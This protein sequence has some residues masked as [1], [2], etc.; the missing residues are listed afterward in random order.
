MAG[1][2]HSRKLDR[3]KFV[4]KDAVVP[5]AES[6]KHGIDARFCSLCNSAAANQQSSHPPKRRRAAVHDNRHTSTILLNEIVGYLNAAQLRATYGAV[7]ELVGGIAQSVGDRLGGVAGRR[8]EASWVVNSETEMPTG[9]LPEQ[10][11]PALRQSS[12]VIRNG[13]ELWQ[14]LEEWKAAGAPSRCRGL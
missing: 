10:W 11:H 9:Y 4:G 1:A 7:A 6:C 3:F 14:R 8:P 2:V 12:H 5:M 13:D